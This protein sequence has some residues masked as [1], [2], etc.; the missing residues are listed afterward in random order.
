[1]NKERKNIR[2]KFYLIHKLAKKSWNHQQII[3]KATMPNSRE[4]GVIRSK[5]NS[6]G[7]A[8]FKRW[9]EKEKSAKEV[10]V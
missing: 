8:A 10:W 3:T 6:S 2:S 4:S 7:I 5:K 9:I 1:M